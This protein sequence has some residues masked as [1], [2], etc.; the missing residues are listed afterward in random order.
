MRRTHIVALL[1]LIVAAPAAALCAKSLLSAPNA[2]CFSP[3]QIGYRLSDAE[4]ADYTV[5]IDNGASRP[6]LTLQVVDEPGL[7]DF[8]LADGSDDTAQCS[9]VT[10]IRSIRLDPHARD[11]DL[12]I[13][14]STTAAGRYRI[15]ARSAEF[16]TQDAAALFAVMTQTGRKAAALRN[17]AAHDDIT[18]AL[19]RAAAPKAQARQ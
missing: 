8:V 16:T 10:A 11:P 18:G 14:L 9:G 4:N 5:K 15:Y 3:G 1:T 7:A 17:I 13:A 12:T 6:D 19:G 2:P